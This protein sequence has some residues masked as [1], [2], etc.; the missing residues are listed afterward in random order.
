MDH[1]IA[2]YPT[3]REDQLGL[4]PTA[5]AGAMLARFD[6]GPIPLA[7]RLAFAGRA[8]LPAASDASSIAA[9]DVVEGARR[10]SF[11]K[12]GRYSMMG[13]IPFFRPK[14]ERWVDSLGIVVVSARRGIPRGPFE[15]GLC[16][17][18]LVTFF[19]DGS[20][21]ITWSKRNAPVASTDRSTER[22]GT[23][24]LEFD[25][26]S[27]LEAV[28]AHAAH[29]LAVRDLDTSLA[30]SSYYDRRLRPS[31]ALNILF[32]RAMLVFVVAKLLLRR[33]HHGG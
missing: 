7:H 11:R 17:Y 22:G 26:E 8:Y 18:I 1:P 14:R 24:S 2:F 15:A 13:V 29:P 10:R 12:L 30:L 16:K 3:A 20:C 32:L 5:D 6:Q 27:H 4:V 25:Y 21:I 9:K 23:G 31:T 19:D 28:A 33:F